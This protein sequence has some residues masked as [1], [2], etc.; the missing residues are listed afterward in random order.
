[1]LKFVAGAAFA[2][3]SAA[4]TPASYQMYYTDAGDCDPTDTD[5]NP[6][7][8]SSG[9]VLTMWMQKATFNAAGDLQQSQC[10]VY[11]ARRRVKAI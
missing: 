6:N 11:C 9:P 7:C 2:A 4:A 5:D 8:H 1:M 10:G 3:A